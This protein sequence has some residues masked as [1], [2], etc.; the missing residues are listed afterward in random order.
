MANEKRKDG[1]ALRLALLFF[2]LLFV[3]IVGI[4][5][6]IIKIDVVDG[7]MWR[8]KANHCTES[9]IDQPA[10]RG[11]IYSS[12]GNILAST[13]PV[14]DFVL[15]MG[16]VQKTKP[17]GQPLLN[18]KGQKILEP[19]IPDSSFTKHLDSVCIILSSCDPSR[20]VSDFKT[21]IL[22]ERA[23]GK[24]RCYKVARNLP[25]TKWLQLTKTP[26][27]RRGIV[28]TVDG[29][30]V[31]HN[32][33]S[34]TYG[35]L[36]ENVIGFRNS[37][38]SGTYTGLEGNYNT[39]LKGQDGK[40]LRRRLTMGVWLPV[41]GGREYHDS[42]T[43]NPEVQR[44]VING[45]HIIS[46]I[47]TRYQDIAENSLRHRLVNSE[48]NRV[49]DAGCCILMEIETGNILACS[50][51]VRDTSYKDV[52]VFREM[53]NQ[54]IACS[55]G[56]HPGS[57]FK[58]VILTAIMNDT[59]IDTA[60]RV[61]AK[62]KRYPNT[63]K[64]I[65]DDHGD[66]DTLSVKQ[67]IEISS[68]VGMCELGW[69][70]Y[71]NNRERLKK[72]VERVFPYEDLNIDLQT[73]KV[74]SYINNLAPN[75]NFVNYCYGYS[76]FVTPM[77]VLTFYNALGG[78]GRMVRPRFCKG[79]IDGHD[80]TW[81]KPQVM[82]ESICSPQV[83]ATMKDLLVN[84]VQN[85]TGNNI[86]NNAYGIAGKTGTAQ[87]R[88]GH[89]EQGYIASFAGY[90]PAENPKYTCLVAIFR[91]SMYGR[92]SAEVFKDVADCVMAMDKQLGSVKLD[93]LQKDNANTIPFSPKARQSE[94]L[95]AYNILSIPYLSTDSSS[96][97]TIYQQGTDSLGTRST[98]IP[99]EVP[100]LVPDCSGMTVRNAITLLKRMGYK[101][102]FSGCGRVSSQTPK[103]R[104]SLRKGGTV[105]LTLDN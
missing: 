24:K 76:T 67:V 93:Y 15:D 45:R 36:A 64:E 35:N 99:Y 28:K 26:G 19:L 69:T 97:W 22:S 77:Q 68:N 48:G 91:T 86:K 63:P 44:P 43:F 60:M 50:N 102:K 21:A 23:K 59:V 8:R 94:L 87:F 16:V 98:Y 4:V 49:G 75:I 12:D 65:K 33:R 62:V 1:S 32:I 40:L 20:S 29:E 52:N 80:T 9:Y 55:W 25:Y 78:G 27:W 10:Q 83:A 38:S 96:Y 88:V 73:G 81:F 105:V 54:N 101:V 2:L 70:Y 74:K 57:T 14:C 71:R 39:D 41:E 37:I 11:N 95:R 3:A 31:I 89:P 72:A 51:L 18:D 46:T 58:S 34:H 56:Y 100:S 53:P 79:I 82:R 103:A 92:Q 104:T 6:C 61:R 85:G 90:F 47:D 13:I 66:L 7:D 5:G 17:N 84:V 42:L 30:S